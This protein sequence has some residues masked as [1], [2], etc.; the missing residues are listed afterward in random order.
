ME[1]QLATRRESESEDERAGEA[2]AETTAAL[3]ELRLRE[4]RGFPAYPTDLGGQ[5][6]H[7]DLG[8]RRVLGGYDARFHSTSW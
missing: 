5:L 8:D 1:G 4:A 7:A 6:P 3:R 2:E